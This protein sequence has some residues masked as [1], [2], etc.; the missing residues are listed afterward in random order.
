[1]ELPGDLPHVSIMKLMM[2]KI[3]M[4]ASEVEFNMKVL[5]RFTE[6]QRPR[7]VVV[8]SK[9]SQEAMTPVYKLAGTVAGIGIGVGSWCCSC[10]GWRLPIG[11]SL[12]L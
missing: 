11:K 3:V 9:P 1:M 7:W 8:V 5:R 12:C 10:W 2:H 6:V 4:G